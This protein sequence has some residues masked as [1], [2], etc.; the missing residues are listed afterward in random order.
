M[1]KSI[2]IGSVGLGCTASAVPLTT[3]EVLRIIEIVLVVLGAL[4]TYVVMPLYNHFKEAKKDGKIDAEEVKQGV[5]IAVSGAQQVKEELDK[6][7]QKN[8]NRVN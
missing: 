8:D 3:S 6:H 2:I 4:L 7:S 1:N 5:E